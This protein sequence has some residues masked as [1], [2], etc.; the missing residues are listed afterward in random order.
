MS[1]NLLRKIHNGWKHGLGGWLIREQ[2]P[3]EPRI[4]KLEEQNRLLLKKL[5]ELSIALDRISS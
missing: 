5:E 4:K 1:D 2:S 3:D